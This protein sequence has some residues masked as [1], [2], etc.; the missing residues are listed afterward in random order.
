MMAYEDLIKEIIKDPVRIKAV[1]IRYQARVAKFGDDRHLSDDLDKTVPI[2]MVDINRSFT[3][4]IPQQAPENMI[5]TIDY[6][7]GYIREELDRWLE[8]KC[9]RDIS[10]YHFTVIVD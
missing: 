5:K 10:Y 4:D 8:T 1:K 3:I 7:V 2:E 6:A 9:P